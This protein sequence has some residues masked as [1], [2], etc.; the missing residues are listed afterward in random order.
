M[1]AFSDA[2]HRSFVMIGVRWCAIARGAMRWRLL[3]PTNFGQLVV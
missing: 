1:T 2:L 3:H